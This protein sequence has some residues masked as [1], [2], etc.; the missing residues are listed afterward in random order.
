V[1]IGTLLQANIGIK[2]DTI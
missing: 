2:I 1:R